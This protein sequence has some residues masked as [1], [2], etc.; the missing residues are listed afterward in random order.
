MQTK[1]IAIFAIE[2]NKSKI[3]VQTLYQILPQNLI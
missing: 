2:T 3:T 1:T